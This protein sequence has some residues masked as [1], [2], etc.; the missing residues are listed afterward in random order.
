LQYTQDTSAERE[1]RGTFGSIALAALLIALGNIASRVLGL[2]R[3]GTIAAFFGRGT[4]VDAFA[5]AWTVP[6]IL[7][8]MLINGAVSAALVPVFSEYAEGD[9][10]EFW[11]IV[12]RVWNLLLL[13]LC[14]VVVLLV[15]QAPLLAT[16]LVQVE[17]PEL[18]ALTTQLLR[19]LLPSVLFM[20]LSALLTA[21]LYARRTFLM[22]AFAGAIFNAGIILGAVVLHEQFGIASL[23]AGTL[24]G[25]IGQ[26]LL[27]ATGLRGIRYRFVLDLRHPVLRQ[28]VL[29]YAPVTIGI[30]FSIIGMFIDRR[31]ASGFENALATMQYATTLI[32]FPLG[33]IAAAVSLA[34]LPTLSRQSAAADETAFSQ[35]LGMGL[36]VVLLLVV[37]A[38]LGL[39]ILALPI[40]ELLFERRAFSERDT[41][42]TA[43]ALLFYLPGLPAAAI[44]QVLLFAFYARKNTLT[45][46]LVQG[47]AIGIYLLTVTVLLQT[48]AQLGFLA[49]ILGNSAQWIG[50]ALL[51]FWLL[52]RHV[53]LRGVRVGEA[54]L[55]TLTAGGLMALLVHFLA[56]RMETA[57]WIPV[58]GPLVMI[59]IAAGIGVL[60]YLGLCVLLRVEALDYFVTALL[61]RMR[62]RRQQEPAS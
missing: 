4:A 33:L 45:P 37:P 56:S 46:N 24:I 49:L 54:L 19:L 53:S 22:P 41:R 30:G 2:G 17:Y 59:I 26:V 50:H 3:A 18:R 35:T 58:R 38:T 62:G 61:R 6:S 11:G 44:D 31:L 32:Q 57:A 12:S 43:T 14:L 39:A 42:A 16:I 21:V 34:V 28:I 25:G 10:D 27:Q 13:L 40:T 5:A 52:R 23:A 15:W 47:A 1:Q 20:G 48:A 36:K 29:L 7:Y 60:A 55:K 51:L 8:D 9:Q